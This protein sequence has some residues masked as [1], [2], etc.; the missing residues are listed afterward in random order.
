MMVSAVLQIEF[1]LMFKTGLLM[2]TKSFSTP[3]KFDS[4]IS[5]E[6]KNESLIK[7]CLPMIKITSLPSLSE[8]N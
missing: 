1:P 3:P 4:E 8:I 7:F 5:C 2:S 6:Q